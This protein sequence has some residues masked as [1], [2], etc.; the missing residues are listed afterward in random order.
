MARERP[1]AA[2]SSACTCTTLAR[3]RA[4]T[5]RVFGLT[6]SYLSALAR[7]HGEAGF[8][9]TLAS[10]R[11]ARA[12]HLLRHSSAPLTEIALSCG[13]ASADYFIRVFRRHVGTT[14][15]RLRQAPVRAAGQQ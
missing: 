9:E 12:R 7:E 6:P 3:S 11:L 5:A 2:C 4:A 8:S 15:A 1:G 10:I 14:P 13:F